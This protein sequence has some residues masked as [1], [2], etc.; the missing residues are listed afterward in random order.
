MLGALA[1]LVVG[2]EVEVVVRQEA[3][4]VAAVVMMKQ[5]MAAAVG[6]CNLSP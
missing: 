6:G 2:V 1:E 4:E 5:Q 3:Q